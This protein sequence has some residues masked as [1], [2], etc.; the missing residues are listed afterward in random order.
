MRSRRA[1]QPVRKLKVLSPAGR[2]K[3]LSAISSPSASGLS[4]R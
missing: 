4:S 3:G 1:I 2:L